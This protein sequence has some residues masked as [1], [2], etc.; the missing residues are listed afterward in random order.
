MATKQ[1]VHKPPLKLLVVTN[2][3]IA[4]RRAGLRLKETIDK[5]LHIVDC[6]IDKRDPIGGDAAVTIDYREERHLNPKVKERFFAKWD[7]RL[8]SLKQRINKENGLTLIPDS[9]HEQYLQTLVKHHNGAPWLFF[10]H[11]NNH[12]FHDSLRVC[13]QLQVNYNVNVVLFSWPSRSYNPRSIPH[14]LASALML[15]HPA[16][17]TVARL[18]AIKSIYER[19]NQ[20]RIARKLAVK[21]APALSQALSL[22]GQSLVQPLQQDSVPVHMLVHS[23]GHYLLQ[24]TFENNSNENNFQFDKTIFHQA[25]IDSADLPKIVKSCSMINQHRLYVTHNR[26]DYA[27]FLSGLW[28]NKMRPQKAYSRLGNASQLDKSASHQVIDLTGIPGVGFN[29]GILWQEKL[30]SSVKERVFQ[31]LNS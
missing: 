3:C 11:G 22:V 7:R 31:L 21:S 9:D 30:S 5:R 1:F 27:L 15:A 25:D 28:N 26:K 13:R 20:Y 17:G 8:T 2:R 16:M 29:H 18:T 4:K 10:L 14:L 6:D 12:T 23:L 19:H 24:L